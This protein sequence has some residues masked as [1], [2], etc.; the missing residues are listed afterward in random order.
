MGM[1]LEKHKKDGSRRGQVVLHSILSIAMG[2]SP[3]SRQQ[4]SFCAR[5]RSTKEGY[6]AIRMR[7][8]ESPLSLMYDMCILLY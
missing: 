5:R 8:Q 1:G 3:P 6:Q 2:R 4:N 7:Q